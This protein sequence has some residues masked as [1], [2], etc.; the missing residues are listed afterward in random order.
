[1]ETNNIPLLKISVLGT[2]CSTC[3]QLFELV[4][5]VVLEMG[6]N[7]PVEYSTDVQRIINLGL[8]TSPVLA[9]NDIPVLVGRTKD[10]WKIKNLIE[11]SLKND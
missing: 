5:K 8:L 10:K 4:E 6:L 7:L 3:R 1:M 2:G 9:I 11:T